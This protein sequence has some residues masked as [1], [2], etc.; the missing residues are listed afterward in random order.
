MEET[1]QNGRVVGHEGSEAERTE[2]YSDWFQRPAE[3]LCRTWI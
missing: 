1:A 3:A 2:H